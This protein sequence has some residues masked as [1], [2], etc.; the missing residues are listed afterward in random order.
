MHAPHSAE[1][2]MG[3]VRYWAASTLH[4]G[5]RAAAVWSMPSEVVHPARAMR[6]RSAVRNGVGG[7]MARSVQTLNDRRDGR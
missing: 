4:H 3:G 1:V 2:R 5:S 6:R 7:P